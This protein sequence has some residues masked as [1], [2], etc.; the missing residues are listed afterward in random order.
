VENLELQ[1]HNAYEAER[2]F[3]SGRPLFVR[4]GGLANSFWNEL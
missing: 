4:E 3:G 1:A 2:Y